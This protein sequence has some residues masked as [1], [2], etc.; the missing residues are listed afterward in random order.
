M[1]LF[2]ILILA[3]AL[4][5]LCSYGIITYIRNLM[6]DCG[7]LKSQKHGV[8][9]IIVGNLRVGGTGKTPF[10]EMLLRNMAAEHRIAVISRGYGRRTKGFRIINDEDTAVSVGDEPLQ[11]HNKYSKLAL[12]AVSED[13]NLA[14]RSIIAANPAID[15]IILDDA[16]QHR[17][18]RADKTYLL[19]AYNKPYFRD[20]VLPFG[21]LREFAIGK[22]RSDVIVVTKCP[23]NLSN[24]ER[25]YFIRKIKPQYRQ[26][27]F[28]SIDYKTPYRFRKP[29]KVLIVAQ[30][31][32][33]ILL[34]AIADNHSV[35]S[36]LRN[37]A[38]SLH[39]IAF[40]DHHNFTH[41]DIKRIKARI[42]AVR[43]PNTIII[44]TEKDAARLPHDIQ[45]RLSMQVYV[46][47]IECRLLP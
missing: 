16:Y 9:V 1:S 32:D 26:V 7:I 36:Y 10:V 23:P 42:I 6:F 3:L 13:R 39:I 31:P 43:R 33:V 17:Y 2:T 19:T 34:S 44:T 45:I 28:A 22:R 14:I 4:L 18:V 30:K 5:L 46:L 41:R 40:K 25:E 29:D 27:L 38:Q 11:M 15:T 20:K 24:D 35:I 21:M 47:P 12:F 8:K 37:K